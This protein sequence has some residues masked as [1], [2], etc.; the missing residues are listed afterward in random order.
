[1]G[2]PVYFI[3]DAHLGLSIPH[4]NQRE[5][6]LK[7]FLRETAIHCSD[8]YILG[9]LFDFWI[10]YRYAIR[11]DYFSV[12]FEF[13][14]LIEHGV[15][16]HYTAGNHDFALGVF[17]RDTIGLSIHHDFLCTE[18]QGKKVYMAH[19][20][21]L[22]RSD[23]GYRIIKPILRNR[24]NQRLYR[25]LHPSVGIPLAL[26]FSRCSRHLMRGAVLP[27]KAIE[28]Y[29]TEAKRLLDR[30][31]DIVLFGHTHNP[32]FVWYGKKC[33][34]NIGEWIRRYTFG[35]MKEGEI[36]LWEYDPSTRS[37]KRSGV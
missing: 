21:G 34:C 30:G 5:Q 1:M 20:D 10:E 19:G 7:S 17:L 13:K 3:S 15:A 2:K 14:R 4:Y 29:R 25:M 32:D 35:M 37:T 24:I 23:V 36:T 28:G 12:L 27:Q 31:N 18:I 26:F 16:I 8:L 33:Y 6:Y 11:P 22:L 9:D